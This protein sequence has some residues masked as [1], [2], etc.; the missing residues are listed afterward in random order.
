MNNTQAWSALVLAGDRGRHDPVAQATGAPCKALVQAGGTPLLQRVLQ[1]LD[2]CPAIEH[3]CVVGPDSSLIEQN[4]ALTRIMQAVEA[5][6]IS[7]GTSPVASVLKGLAALPQ[8]NPVLITT[9]DHALLTP[10]MVARMCQPQ[11]QL[12]LGVGL[13][14]HSIIKQAYPQSRRTTTR[15]G[16][17]CYCGCNLFALHH[18]RGR[19]LIERWRRVEQQRKHPIRIVAGMLGWQAVLAYILRFLSLQGAFERLS[20][21][22]GVSTGPILLTDPDSAVDVDSVSDWHQVE[23]ILAER[24]D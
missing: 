7:P 1:T 4:P 17:I 16:G 15:L 9:A 3:C 11:E 23:A 24:R 2:Q 8:N 10:A 14:D 12:D 18:P 19:R 13:I 5:E 21:R 20:R 6:W 22:H